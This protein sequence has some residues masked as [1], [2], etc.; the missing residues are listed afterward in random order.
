L[1]GSAHGVEKGGLTPLGREVVGRLEQKKILIDLAHSSPRTIDDV[2][3]MA[4]RPVFASHTGVKGT[5]DNARNLSDDQL[6]GIAKT[7]GVVGIGF[8]PTAVCGPDAHA[9]ARAIRYA[10]GVAGVDH[11]GLGSDF[12]GAVTEP[13]DATG[14]PLLTEALLQDGLAED[15]VAKIMGGNVLRVLA[16]TLP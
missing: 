10:V 12:D 7:G 9:I 16:Q 15:D 1:A 4:T 3:A 14:L 11:V 13:F 8:W 6:R 5:C 2:L